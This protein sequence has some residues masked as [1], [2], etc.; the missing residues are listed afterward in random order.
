MKKYL[1]L[2]GLAFVASSCASLKLSIIRG[3]IS[4]PPS[5][6]SVVTN[7]EL[8][9]EYTV[10]VGDVVISGQRYNKDTSTIYQ[11]INDFQPPDTKDF[12]GYTHKRSEIGKGIKY[13]IIAETNSEKGKGLLIKRT[14]I[15]IDINIKDGT[16]ISINEDGSIQHGFVSI[17][18]SISGQ[19]VINASV[20]SQGEWP[21]GQ[22]F[23]KDKSNEIT[24]ADFKFTITYLGKDNDAIRLKYM[25]YTNDMARPAFSNDITWDL[26]E[27]DVMSYKSIKARIISATN[28]QI[29]LVVLEDGDLNW[30]PK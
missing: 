11:A 13:K 21:Q 28:N 6:S 17:Q 15:P 24:L 22:L 1:L 19:S 20:W 3:S 25:E 9:K 29:K 26:K 10:N 8:N 5:V 23:E 18:T 27:S 2:I 16:P 4:T 14:D 7:Y 30:L 12:G